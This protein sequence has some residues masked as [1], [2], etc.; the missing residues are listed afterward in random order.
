M[1]VKVNLHFTHAILAPFSGFVYL[2]LLKNTCVLLAAIT[3][4]Y[5]KSPHA[6]RVISAVCMSS[7][8]NNMQR[9]SFKGRLRW[10]DLKEGYSTSAVERQVWFALR[11]FERAADVPM[12]FPCH[13]T[14]MGLQGRRKWSHSPSLCFKQA[15]GAVAPV[16]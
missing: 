14:L 12:Q 16:T 4:E 7:Q 6:S 2:N 1:L 9:N 8:N 3:M 15:F 10:K 5:G 11:M 13:G